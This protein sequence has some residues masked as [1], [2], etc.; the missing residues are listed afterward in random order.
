MKK[1]VTASTNERIIRTVKEAS[2][3]Y[4]AF[5]FGAVFG[6]TEN[7]I[8]YIRY[9]LPE[10]KV[11]DYTSSPQINA[12]AI[13]NAINR[14][15]WLHFGGVIA[16]CKDREQQHEI[17][18]IKDGNILSILTVAD[19]EENFGR[20]LRILKKNQQFLYTRGMQDMMGGEEQGSFECENDPVDIRFYT[21]FI[22]S[23]LY[24]TNRISD[25][26][27]VNLQMTLMELLINAV[28]HGNLN[29][30]Y[31]EKNEYLENGGDIFTLIRERSEKPEYRGRR[32]H[33][34][35]VIRKTA[36]AF[37]IR[38]EGEGFNWKEAMEKSAGTTETNGR[39]I[40]LSR[41][42]VQKIAYNE[43]GN[44]VTFSIKNRVNVVNTVPEIMKD[45]D[46]LEYKDK[47]IIFRQDE[48]SNDLFFIVSGRFAVYT[49]Q[50]LSATLT[51]NDIFIGEMAFLLNGRRTATVVSVGDSKL[52]KVPKTAFLKL[53]HENPHYG[54]FLSKMLAQ[55]LVLQS[56][57]S[58]V[59]QQQLEDMQSKLRPVT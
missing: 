55:R 54:I 22:V 52:I 35:Y 7:T 37:R 8:N 59:M 19:F 11:I 9:E 17:E 31:Q 36:S 18:A 24:N 10:I 29:I 47:D 4:E 15:S 32:V 57:T 38:D 41:Q 33:I 43:K 51:P 26:D 56:N 53:I 1:I 58:Y 46:I 30:T 20:L 16:V 6:D 49:N 28:E 44:Q 14:D 50:K 39:G 27:R 3:K 34:S 45:F 40:S 42:C 12:Q 25:E 23:Y 2:A 21:N 48:L 5:F 13:L